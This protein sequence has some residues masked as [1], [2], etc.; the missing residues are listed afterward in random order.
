MRAGS[1]DQR[2]I[3]YIA[4]IEEQTRSIQEQPDSPEGVRGFTKASEPTFDQVSVSTQGLQ[5]SPR[6]RK[7]LFVSL[8]RPF[9]GNK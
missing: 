5:L 2:Q 6:F 3:D 8:P 4:L 7:N 1:L 9:D